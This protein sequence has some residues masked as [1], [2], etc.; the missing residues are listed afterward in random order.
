[1][2]F[3]RY[4]TGILA[5]DHKKANP[6]FEVTVN[7]LSLKKYLLRFTEVDIDENETVNVKI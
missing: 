1:M 2:F 7:V 3:N 6:L 5:F 4:V